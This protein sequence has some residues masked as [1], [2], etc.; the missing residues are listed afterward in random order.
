M[1]HLRLTGPQRVWFLQNTITNDVEGVP[2]GRW[3]ESCFLDAKGKVLAHF[4]AGIFEEEVR[5]SVDEPGASDLRDWFVRYRFRTKVEIEDLSQEFAHATVIGPR[6]SDLAAAGEVLEDG[7][8]VIFGDALGDIPACEVYGP[9]PPNIPEA[10]EDLY[11]MLRIQAG[12]GKFGVDYGPDKL[13]QEAGLTRVVSVTKG[14]YVGQ[15]VMARLHFRGHVNRTLRRLEFSGMDGEFAGR[16]LTYDGQAAGRVTS[17]V[18]FPDGTTLGMGMV[19]VEVPEGGRLSA[20]AGAEA[21]AGP[22][23]EGTKV[24]EKSLRSEDDR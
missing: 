23:P 2:P 10:G 13:P 24:S 22:L 1:G 8:S 3:V 16:S 14:C 18:R 19:R 7:G 9:L 21:I 15:E 4:R 20:G 6:A 11:E 5:L 12:V 17:S